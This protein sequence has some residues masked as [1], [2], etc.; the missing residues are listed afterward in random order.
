MTY[1]EPQKYKSRSDFFND[2]LASLKA[3]I[4]QLSKD[5][6]LNLEQNDYL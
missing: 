2:R 5:E 3:D 1:G 6:V 4:N